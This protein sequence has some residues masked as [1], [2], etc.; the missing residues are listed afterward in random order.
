MAAP[1]QFF[2]ECFSGFISFVCV[3]D[4]LV[5]YFGPGDSIM[6]LQCFNLLLMFFYLKKS[7]MGSLLRIGPIGVL[8]FH[9]QLFPSYVALQGKVWWWSFRGG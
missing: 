9:T 4:V 6:E 5:T 7:T 8:F 2:F 3:V 1:K